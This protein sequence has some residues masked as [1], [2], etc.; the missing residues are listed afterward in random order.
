MPQ[1]WYNVRTQE[2]EVDAQSDWTQLIG[3]Y[4]SREEAERA[5]EKVEERNRAWEAQDED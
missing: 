3:P 4:E 5:P 2:V 1:Y